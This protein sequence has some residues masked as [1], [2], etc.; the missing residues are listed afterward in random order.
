MHTMFMTHPEFRFKGHPAKL[1]Q[2]LDGLDV[3]HGAKLH[4]WL[5]LFVFVVGGFGGSFQ[6]K[7]AHSQDL[8]S[9]V[10]R[11]M[12]CHGQEQCPVHHLHH[13]RIRRHFCSLFLASQVLPRIL[14]CTYQIL[15]FLILSILSHS[16][17]KPILCGLTAAEYSAA[18]EQ[19]S[20][21]IRYVV[22]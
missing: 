14:H 22:K 10:P 12:A 21:R 19:V 9:L 13:C 16:F 5:Q 3:A 2:L 15:G 7:S 18:K 8:A 17:E 1:M 6:N 11:P 20:G 4:P